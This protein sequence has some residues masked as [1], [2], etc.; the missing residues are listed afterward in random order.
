MRVRLSP[1]RIMR[2]AD[3][4]EPLPNG[5]VTYIH[6]FSD[7]FRIA[8]GRRQTGIRHGATLLISGPPGSGKTT[9]ALAT[10]RALMA[11]VA[12]PTQKA[13]AYYISSEV[14]ETTLRSAYESFGWFAPPGTSRAQEAD[15]SRKSH[16]KEGPASAKTQ[17]VEPFTFRIDDPV[18]DITNFYAITPMPEVDRP[19]PSPE[20]LVNGIF[21]RIAHTL[22]PSEAPIENARIYVVVDSISA[23]LKGCANAAE[24][25]RQTHEIIHRLR[26][27]F[28]SNKLALTILLAEQDHR[29]P[30]LG[31]GGSPISPTVPSV[32]DYLADIVFRLYVRS[33]PLGR[34]SRVLEVVKSQGVNMILGEHSWQIITEDNHA[35]V[36]RHKGMQ[37]AIR[38]ACRD[39]VDPKEAR[40]R[41]AADLT[42]PDQRIADGPPLPPEPWGGIVIFPRP[43][44][45]RP[46]M[47][48]KP[49]APHEKVEQWSSGTPGLTGLDIRP[50][51][52]TLIAGP[53]GS[54]KTTL[55][56]QFLTCREEAEDRP[57]EATPDKNAETGVRG[58]ATK[59][60]LVSFDL[61][62]AGPDDDDIEVLDFTQSR[63]DLNVLVAHIRWILDDS[64]A[65]APR[66]L[67]F[68]GLSAWITLFDEPQAAR[69]LEALMITV[70]RVERPPAVFMTYAL[71][72]HD[73]PLGPRALDVNANNIVVIRQIA[74]NDQVRRVLY[75][76][77]GNQI[78]G[79]VSPKELKMNPRAPGERLSLCAVPEALD[80]Y[81]GL[82]GR[83]G[84]PEQANVLLFL[85]H[86]ND[87]ELSLN[88][89]L[90]ETLN[91][92]HIERLRFS[93]SEFSRW[94]IGSTLDRAVSETAGENNVSLKIQSV[95]EWWLGAQKPELFL[96][97]IKGI[98][99]NMPSVRWSDYW[100]FEVEKARFEQ[101]LGRG[102][103]AEPLAIYAVPAS[104]DFGMLCVNDELW[105][106]RPKASEQGKDGADS[107]L[108]DHWG[109]IVAALP[110]F[111]AAETRVDGQTWFAVRKHRQGLNPSLVEFALHVTHQAAR[112]ILDRKAIFSFDMATRETCVC[113]FLE[114]AW[115]FGAQEG[116][117]AAPPGEEREQQIRAAEKAL[118]FL[119]F[120][121]LEG[122]MLDRT[123]IET[124]DKNADTLLSR[125]FYSTLIKHWEQRLG[126][127]IAVPFMPTGFV[128]EEAGLRNAILDVRTRLNY[129]VRR[130]GDLPPACAQ[131]LE[132][133]KKWHA[134]DDS[135]TPIRK[136]ILDAVDCYG[137][138]RQIVLALA[139]SSATTRPRKNQEGAADIDDLTELT[140][141][142]ALRLS[143]L[144]GNDSGRFPSPHG[145]KS[146]SNYLRQTM[147]A[148]RSRHSHLPSPAELK[149]NIQDHPIIT[150]YSCVGSW[151][152]GVS[153]YSRSPSLRGQLLH[154]M[155]SLESAQKRGRSRGG[156]P[157][158]KD[159]FHLHG[160]D[161]VPE[162]EYLNWREFLRYNGARARR[163]DRVFANK[164]TTRETYVE[165]QRA[166]LDCLRLAG[167][168]KHSYA[169]GE[170]KSV[171]AKIGRCAAEAVRNIFSTAHAGE[172]SRK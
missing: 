83:A 155:T 114:F 169:S 88:Q 105:K 62:Q 141:W 56:R 61:F 8:E 109:E 36:L 5:T 163:R 157:A 131:D 86:E 136:T 124:E 145:A 130:A 133:I 91:R 4:V 146:G 23:L 126:R 119:Q 165:I 108:R 6:G 48:N 28:G 51:T 27:R 144:L 24:E 125:H 42:K 98:W 71:A 60:V 77:K 84:V 168:H 39:C 74:I 11:E 73:D 147:H 52:T 100:S 69:M 120:M 161:E 67:A 35:Q 96:Q 1:N 66:R 31:T 82:L 167:L 94:E 40:I 59:P 92:Q 17:R 22:L 63:F 85:F 46:L 89:D 10:I 38:R 148:M 172:R 111:W 164:E 90:C 21:N 103:P 26:D 99:A 158:R 106:K 137:H 149:Q 166:M 160:D 33:L 112:D 49:R 102:D 129:W 153:K 32:E 135:A 18:P 104:I 54:G 65:T 14:D 37:R 20:E 152:Y 154:E 50:G 9:F 68:D 15:D 2:S 16:A 159:Y 64:G 138:C 150:G 95:D 139:E 3:E 113:V 97:N 132:A 140:T 70:D 45:Q 127:L 47:A 13:I 121:V 30:D 122:L 12:I 110:R 170:R 134:A 79:H 93:H 80:Y 43:L 162:M 142:A 123:T 76:I 118:T 151:M 25:R 143:L 101:P 87:K 34:R 156:M 58:Q 7:L 107:P 55:C 117:L 128:D 75:Y 171:I 41:A 57:D 115:A 72:H 81:T 44:L 53:V 116:M 29:A 78:A 19:V